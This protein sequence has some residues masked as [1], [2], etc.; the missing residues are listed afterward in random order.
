[1]KLSILTATYNRGDLLVRLYQSILNNL[2]DKL[3]IEWLIMDDGSTDNTEDIVKRFKEKEGFHIK[4]FKQRNQGKMQAINNLMQY[5]TGELVMDCD[6]DDYFVNNSFKEI[7]SKKD[8]LFEND[9]YALIFLK[10]EE[11]NQIS[12]NKFKKENLDTTMFDM[13]FKEGITGEKIL[14]FKTDIRT[15]YKH[16]I[17]PNEKFITEARMYHKMDLSYGVR[18]FNIPIVEG[19]YLNNGYTSNINKT[20]IESPNGYYKYFYEILQ[21]NMKNVEFKKR[22][23][24]IKHYI[25][26]TYILHKK[27]DVK[28]VNDKI[29]K[30]LLY[31]LFIPGIIKIKLGGIYGK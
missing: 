17:E 26:F 3:S 7:Y 29:N 18:C 9:L 8:I 14:V 1:M 31:V 24:A 12:G 21:R 23:Y 11:N 19:R 4:F 13:Y 30:I 6:S 27:L 16:E 22:L 5:V 15:K 10:Y 25:L 20:F 28:K 2:Y